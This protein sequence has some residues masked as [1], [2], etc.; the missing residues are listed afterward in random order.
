MKHHGEIGRVESAIPL[1]SLDNCL[2]AEVFG[3][4]RLERWGDRQ[5]PL[6]RPNTRARSVSSIAF[7]RLVMATSNTSPYCASGFPELLS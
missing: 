5:T 7:E 4:W 1:K 2:T 3:R 6:D